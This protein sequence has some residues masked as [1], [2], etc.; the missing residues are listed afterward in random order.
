MRIW[1]LIII[2]GI[3]IPNI[4]ALEGMDPGAPVIQ[5]DASPQ[6]IP[7]LVFQ[8]EFNPRLRILNVW[9][10]DPQDIV[11]DGVNSN[12]R[13]KY[14]PYKN[15]REVEIEYI[16][17]SGKVIRVPG[18]DPI[19][20]RLYWANI[21]TTENGI[22][23]RIYKEGRLIGEE[24]FQQPGPVINITFQEAGQGVVFLKMNQKHNGLDTKVSWDGGQTWDWVDGFDKET[25]TFKLPLDKLEKNPNPILEVRVA[26]NLMIYR[27]RYIYGKG[28]VE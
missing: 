20:G 11:F 5:A 12:Q 14:I 10:K 2:A 8:A 9:L 26:V 24:H 18:L 3:F 19:P 21:P 23:Y 25:A 15:K 1:N 7:F 4:Q 16:T 28:P 22:G 17:S 13:S 6:E 27:K